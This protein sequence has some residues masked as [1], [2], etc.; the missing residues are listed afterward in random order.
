MV[1]LAVWTGLRCCD[2]VAL[3]LEEIDWR[4]DEI[5]LVQAKTSRPPWPNPYVAF[6]DA[7][8]SGRVRAGACCGAWVEVADAGGGLQRVPVTNKKHDRDLGLR[9]PLTAVHVPKLCSNYHSV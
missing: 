8:N 9:T 5:R 3:R 2:I 1:L 6:P 4:H 7:G